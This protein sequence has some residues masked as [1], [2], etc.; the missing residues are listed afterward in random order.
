MVLIAILASSTALSILIKAPL[1]KILDT[2][3]SLQILIHLMLV[4][5]A[6]PA[7]STFFFG[8]LMQILNFQFYDFT[9][10]YCRV[11]NLDEAGQQPF[12]D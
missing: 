2:V 8:I 5:I 3:K 6:Y 12:T 4:N 9:D 10:F 7:T 1:Q 11:L